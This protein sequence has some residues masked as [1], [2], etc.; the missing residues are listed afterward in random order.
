MGKKARMPELRAVAEE[1]IGAAQAAELIVL[2]DLEARW[3]NLRAARQETPRVS[4][5][6]RDL[7]VMQKAYDAFRVQLKAYQASFSPTHVSEL[8][9]NT[10]AR[11]GSW[12][13]QVRDLHLRAG[14]PGP[15]HSPV[16]LLEKAYRWADRLA[17]KRGKDRVSR[18]TPPGPAEAVFRD[19]EAIAA[20]C[21]ALP[22]GP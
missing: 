5:I 6:A 17:G 2:L 20:W 14:Q 12:C 8:L 21:D 16:H 13:R 10:P 4:S 15:A 7:L 9:L 18:A 22:P 3:E 11:L 1:A 19:L